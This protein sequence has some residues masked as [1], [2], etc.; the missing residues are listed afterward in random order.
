MESAIVD[1]VSITLLIWWCVKFGTNET[2]RD[3]KRGQAPS[4][5][6]IG[7]ILQEQYAIWCK[8]SEYWFISMV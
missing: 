2:C 5:L 3:V 4:C 7:R 8:Q 1:D 6:H